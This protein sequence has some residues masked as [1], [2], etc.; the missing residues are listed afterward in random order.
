MCSLFPGGH[1][2]DFKTTASTIYEVFRKQAETLWYPLQKSMYRTGYKE[3]L[4][5]YPAVASWVAVE[6]KFPY[7][8]AL[9]PVDQPMIEYGDKW[10]NFAMDL[11]KECII[12]KDFPLRQTK[13]ETMVPSDYAM[14]KLIPK[15]EDY[16]WEH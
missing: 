11:L 12:R 6:N 7:E 13:A 2:V 3:I 10:Y 1:L 8:P 16:A 14:A 9:F 4:G 15:L 5:N